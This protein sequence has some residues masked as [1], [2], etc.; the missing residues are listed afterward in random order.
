MGNWDFIKIDTWWKAVFYLGIIST[1]GSATFEI[2]FIESKHLFGLGVGLIAIGVGYWKSWKT[3]SQVNLR[4]ILKWKD[5][6]YDAISII[7]IVIG[8]L[9]IGL[10][11]FLIIKGLI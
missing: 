4:G 1:I 3:F 2:S 11:G 5:Y 8:V 6:D 7:L 9:L 10:F